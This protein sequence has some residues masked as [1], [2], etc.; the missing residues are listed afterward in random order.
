MTAPL[1][2]D[3][4]FRLIAA[5][6]D[7]PL[8]SYL[9]S[10]EA[11]EEELNSIVPRYAMTAFQYAIMNRYS[12]N[13]LQS[14]IR[15]GADVNAVDNEGNSGLHYAVMAFRP[16]LIPMLSSMTRN[17]NA[18]NVQGET[19]LHV[20]IRLGRSEFI[21]PLLALGVNPYVPDNRGHVPALR[22][23]R[24]APNVSAEVMPSVLVILIV[25]TIFQAGL[26]ARVVNEV[27]RTANAYNAVYQL[28]V[29]CSDFLQRFAPRQRY[30]KGYMDSCSYAARFWW[31]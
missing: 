31:W 20:A 19:A 27:L 21:E 15:F 25:N 8:F 18:A 4:L 7:V 24:L 16:D 30:H 13:Q 5:Q 22:L 14:L 10:I 23:S 1:C 3:E 28:A 12:R 9:G 29:M 2:A 17:V 26:G 6:E 11:P